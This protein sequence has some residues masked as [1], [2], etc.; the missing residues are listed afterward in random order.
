MS[1]AVGGT[2]TTAVDTTGRLRGNRTRVRRSRGARESAMSGR[3]WH[4]LAWMA[5]LMPVAMVMIAASVY[6][7]LGEKGIAGSPSLWSLALDLCRVVTGLFGL[8]VL[9]SVVPGRGSDSSRQDIFGSIAG[10]VVFIAAAVAGLGLVIVVT[11]LGGLV[12]LY[13]SGA[14]AVDAFRCRHREP[15]RS[16]LVRHA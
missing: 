16:D 9:V 11:G 15:A 3:D 8:F 12:L 14:V 7:V 2:H 10:G 4:S 1:Q 6:V 13:A 5:A